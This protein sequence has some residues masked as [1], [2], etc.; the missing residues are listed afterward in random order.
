MSR[1]VTAIRNVGPRTAGLFAR[2]GIHSAEEVEALGAVPA[3]LRLR[4]AGIRMSLVGLYALYAGLQGRDWRDLM[5][6][7]KAALRAGAKTPDGLEAAL[8]RLGLPRH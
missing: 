8:D 3:Y 4:A 2:A 7:E 5:P 1:P 6:D